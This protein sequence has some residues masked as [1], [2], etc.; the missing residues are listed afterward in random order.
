MDLKDK[1]V[2]ITGGSLGIGKA[3]AALLAEAGAKVAITGRSKDRLQATADELGV[4]AIQ[5]DVAEASDVERTY[6]EFLE[7]FS[8]LDVLVNNAAVGGWQAL[9]DIDPEKMTEVWKINVLGATLMAKEAAKLFIEQN[10]GNIINIASTAAQK[11][12]AKGSIYS[13]TK[14]ALRGLSECWRAELRPHNV[15]VTTI[16]PSEVTTAFGSEDGTERDEQ[17][18]KLRAQ[19]IAHTI[20]A[21][22]EMDERGFIPEL[23]VFAT[24]PW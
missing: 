15:R 10:S 11:G 18:N 23:S 12:Y 7:Q 17:A 2:L 4:F 6:A 1:K 9:C 3:T 22:L 8:S 13:S 19:E 21:A 16:C 5:A 14:F 20:R 24:N